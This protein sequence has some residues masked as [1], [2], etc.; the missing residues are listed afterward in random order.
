MS[1]ISELN[2]LLIRCNINVNKLEIKLNEL[3][4]QLPSTVEELP[5]KIPRVTVE[6]LASVK[7]RK[8]N[9]RRSPNKQEK[10]PKEL[11]Q[12]Q[13]KKTRNVIGSTMSPIIMSPK[14]NSKS[15]IKEEEK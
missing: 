10:T 15:E 6:Q 9:I 8:T 13:M 3:L 5:P 14:S 1:S 4:S 12:E 2:E 7:L 11:F